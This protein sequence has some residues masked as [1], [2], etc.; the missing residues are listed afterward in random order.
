MAKVEEDLGIGTFSHERAF[1][2]ERKGLGALGT[3][4]YGKSL[5]WM[6]R[7]P[8]IPKATCLIVVVS[9]VIKRW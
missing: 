2:K 3:G 4:Y 8:F 5:M 7:S 6:Y 1:R 9:D